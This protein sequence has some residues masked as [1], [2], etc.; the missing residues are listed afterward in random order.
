V[1]EPPSNLEA[2]RACL[3]GMMVNES[4]LKGVLA[5]GLKPEHFYRNAHGL[6]FRACA[7][8]AALNSPVDSIQVAGELERQGK[9]SEA[10]G[11]EGVT[12]LPGESATPFNAPQHALL[13]I[14]AAQYRAYLSGAS[15][16]VQGVEQR[17]RERIHKGIERAAADLE[18]EAE[19]VEPHE[20]ADEFA[21]YM[22]SPDP[23]QVYSTGFSRLD[24]LAGGGLYPGQ[25][26][27]LIGWTSDGKTT[28]VDGICERAREKGDRA[29]I[30]ATEM[31]RRDRIARFIAS[32]TLIP[33]KHLMLKQL[34]DD[35]KQKVMT[36]LDDI[37]YAYR[38]IKGWNVD[39]VCT[40]IAM[41]KPDL[42]VLDSIHGMPYRDASELRTISRRLA[43]TAY[44]VGCHLL[45]VCQLNMARATAKDYPEPVERDIRDSG[46]IA[47]DVDNIMSIYRTRDK[48]GQREATGYLR[49]QKVR[50]GIAGP[51]LAVELV[52][53]GYGFRVLGAKKKD[54]S[55]RPIASAY[56]S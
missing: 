47:Y 36:V 43:A 50:N 48:D 29:L 1:T 25:I 54:E 5:S 55:Q 28:L 20:L 3:G 45:I 49:W 12:M 9:L 40:E 24:N 37:P 38:D 11:R 18:H 27:A 46:S 41:R 39:Q 30:L 23:T 14:E 33:W 8:L 51:R 15:E 2:E 22:F 32:K 16:I 34:S 19:P 42:A 21:E 44:R 13:I 31:P 35:Q 17:D 6:V 56:D 26:T 7:R 4:A 10:G 52:P 53:G